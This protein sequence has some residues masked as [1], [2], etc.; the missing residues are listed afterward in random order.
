MFIFVFGAMCVSGK[1]LQQYQGHGLEFIY[2]SY[3]VGLIFLSLTIAFI[4][5]IVL[6]IYAL[7]KLWDYIKSK[8]SK[9][10]VYG[11]VK[12]VPMINLFFHNLK[13]KHCSLINWK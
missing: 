7:S 5:I 4:V 3:L 1:T 6:F 10:E 13:K 2:K 12:Q 11:E 8:W 9:P